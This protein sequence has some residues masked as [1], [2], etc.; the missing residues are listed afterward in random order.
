[1]IGGGKQAQAPTLDVAA[2][3]SL[4]RTQLATQRDFIPTMTQTSGRASLGQTA[5]NIGFGLDLLTDPARTIY[6]P[7]SKESRDA[8]SK[9]QAG[10]SDLSGY[11]RVDVGGRAM[12]GDGAGKLLSIKEF[13]RRKAASERAVRGGQRDVRRLESSGDPVDRLQKTFASEF[14]AR[15]RLLK[16]IEG[17]RGSS[18]EYKRMQ[19]AYG[20]GLTAQETGAGALGDR[21]MGEALAK[22][23]QGGQ[24]SPEAARDATQAARSGMAARGMATGSAGLGAEL[25]NRDRYAREREFQNLGFAQSVQTQDL[26]RRQTN[27]AMR[28]DTDR[29]NIGLLGASSQAADGERGR[30]LALGQDAYNFR[31]STNPRM[32]LAGLGQPYANMTAPVMQMVSGAQGLNPM[33]SGGQFSSGGAGGALMGGAMGALSGAASGA[34]LGTTIGPGYGTALGAGLGL[35]GGLTG[36]MGGSR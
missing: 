5:T 2:S 33:Y 23:D 16:D 4:L 31:M 19:D 7:Q 34:A 6:G 22:M 21:L 24:L 9:A 27:T 10:L 28:A 8:L 26:G 11:K 12:M 3:N 14:A 35:L 30:Q 13:N 15:D 36:F 20:R 32:M 25:L 18:A 29:F 1:M 17:A